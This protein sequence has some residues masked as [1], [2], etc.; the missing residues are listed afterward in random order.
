MSSNIF[1][2]MVH[3]YGRAMP[4]EKAIR[5]AM[6][7]CI[8]QNMLKAFLEKHRGEMVNMLISEY[9]WDLAAYDILRL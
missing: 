5:K 9:G 7:D 3:K 4:L 2:D 8:N 1:I 6:E